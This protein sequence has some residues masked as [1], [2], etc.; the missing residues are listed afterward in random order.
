MFNPFSTSSITIYSLWQST[1][2]LL[3]HLWLSAGKITFLF[4]HNSH[5]ATIVPPGPCH[6]LAHMQS[7]LFFAN[8][9]DD[10][11][12]AIC[13]VPGLKSFCGV[14]GSLMQTACVH[15]DLELLPHYSLAEKQPLKAWTHSN[16]WFLLEGE[17]EM[18]PRS[19]IWPTRDECLFVSRI[20]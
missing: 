6:F 9:S 4:A 18:P 2:T 20:V 13:S 3:T 12:S 19:L 8:R 10:R 17:G 15:D 1:Q 14:R 7:L 11:L 5:Q 16:L